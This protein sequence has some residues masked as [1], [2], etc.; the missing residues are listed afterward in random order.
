MLPAKAA[1]IAL[2]SYRS[3]SNLQRLLVWD[4][5][6]GRVDQVSSSKHFINLRDV[7]VSWDGSLW[8]TP[9]NVGG[10]ARIGSR[11]PFYY[12]FGGLDRPGGYFDGPYSLRIPADYFRLVRQKS[13]SVPTWPQPLTVGRGDDP[14]DH[15]MTRDGWV[16]LA[17][18]DFW[19]QLPSRNHPM[20][21]RVDRRNTSFGPRSCFVL[22]GVP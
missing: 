19:S 20:L 9:G 8:L 16:P 10:L 5:D 3:P 17:G 14:L 2:V 1:R 18:Q 21:I 15:K 6:A 11:H 4:I 13:I 12:N 7:D 22:Q